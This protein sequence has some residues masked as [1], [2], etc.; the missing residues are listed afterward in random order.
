[1]L[2]V[3]CLGFGGK[4]FFLMFKAGLETVFVSAKWAEKYY[5]MRLRQVQIMA[6]LIFDTC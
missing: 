5:I 4:I 1:M 3:F 6:L 2:V